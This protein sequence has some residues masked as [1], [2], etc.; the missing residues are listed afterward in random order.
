MKSF[1]LVVIGSG[2]GGYIAAIRAAQLGMSTAIV[3]EEPV[4]GGVCL[5]WGCIPTKAILSSAEIFAAVKHGVPGLVIEGQS[6]N[7]GQV[8]D[9]SRSAADR[10]ARGVASLMRKNKIEVL[11]G[12]ARLAAGK[13]VVVTRDGASESVE[14]R[15]VILAT[16]STEFVFP[17]VQV[18]GKRVLTSREA[19]ES[20]EMPAAIVIIGGGAVGLEFA[21]SYNAYG[22][23]VTIVEMQ[24]Q[25]LPGFDKETADTLSRQFQRSGIKV[26]TKTAYKSL[27]VNGQGVVVHATGEKGD[28][29]LKADQV[30]L[31]VGRRALVADLGLEARG[32]AV[33]RGFIKVD[34]SYRTSAEGV[35]AIGDCSGPPLLAHKASHEGVAAVEII[36]GLRKHGVD[37]K[38]VP[39]CIYCQ[40]QVASVGLSEAEAKAAGH[41]VKVG[42]APFAASGKAVGTG[43]TEGFVK[44]V[45]D[46]KYG[47]I[48]GAQIIG[49]GA[50]ELINEIALA[51][52]IEST[53]TEVGETS[54]AHPTLGEMLMQA[55]LAAEGRALD[56]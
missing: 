31:A 37:L 5:N 50:T 36:A 11:A 39:A 1:D 48:L 46:A 33:E 49:Y 44:I 22:A 56:F 45:S 35:Y 41:E 13:E 16:G 55:A 26:L 29:E 14:A 52:V 23:Q 32:V 18:D 24:D 42:K 40:P 47:E 54:H 27:E 28:V 38:K 4:L 20:R 10:L 2:P 9:A 30:L 7:Y 25:I 34:A 17:G 8:I 12:R 6:A 15:N 21:Y 3:E 53:T 43:H 51:M 19:L